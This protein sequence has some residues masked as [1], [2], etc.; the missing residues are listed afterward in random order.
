MRDSDRDQR[1]PDVSSQRDPQ[2]PEFSLGR[3]ILVSDLKGN[4]EGEYAAFVDLAFNPDARPLSSTR[5]SEIVRPNPEPPNRRVVDESAWVKRSNTRPSFSFGIPMPV[6][7]TVN[8]SAV[9]TAQ[10]PSGSTFSDTWPAAVNLIAL[11]DPM[12]RSFGQPIDL[13]SDGGDREAGARRRR[14]R[15]NDRPERSGGFPNTGHPDRHG[16]LVCRRNANRA[17]RRWCSH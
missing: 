2:E 16:K 14:C 3:L 7:E 8:R 5:R 15:P 6:S 9:G 13:Q 10:S 1:P 11:I 17:T 12:R 4:R